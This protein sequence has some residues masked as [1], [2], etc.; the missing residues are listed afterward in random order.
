M[1]KRLFVIAIVPITD[2]HT[3]KY[4]LY[5]FEKTKKYVVPIEIT[6]TKAKTLLSSE[7]KNIPDIYNT[8]KRLICGM[9]GSFVSATIYK[10]TNEIFYTYLNLAFQN[11]HIEFNADVTDAINLAR[12]FQAPVYIKTKLLDYCG[13]K[14]S[15]KKL[16]EALERGY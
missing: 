4:T 14:V 6:H 8:T 7:E 12:R 5:L 3:R 2:E 9:G 16:K 10:Y 15:K 11:K 1:Y 13:I